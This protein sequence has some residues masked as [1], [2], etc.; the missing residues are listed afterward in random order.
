MFLQHQPSAHPSAALTM[1]P[2]GAR[3]PL[4]VTC[5][6]AGCWQDPDWSS[7]AGPLMP[8]R[9][10]GRPGRSACCQMQPGAPAAAAGEGGASTIGRHAAMQRAAVRILSTCH[11][12]SGSKANNPPTHL[13]VCPGRRQ[14]AA[15]LV[16]VYLQHTQRTWCRDNQC[17]GNQAA[18]LTMCCWVHDA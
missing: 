3:A 6:S 15:E 11:I 8:P 7:W 17:I 18:L 4:L 14:R 12:A 2:A 16:A 1:T 13:R 5:Q 10:A 9:L